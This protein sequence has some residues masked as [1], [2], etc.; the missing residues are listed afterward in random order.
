M[1]NGGVLDE[2]ITASSEL[3]GNSAAY[4]GRLNVN[5]SAQGSTIKSGA[6]VAGTS[7]KVSGYKLIC[8]TRNH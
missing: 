7:V 3:N 1:D 6:W 5:E 8:S 2:Q 4:E